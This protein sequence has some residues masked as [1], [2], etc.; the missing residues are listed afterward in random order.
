M[1]TGIEWTVNI[2]IRKEFPQTFS[3]IYPEKLLLVVIK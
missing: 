1:D 3:E 2:D